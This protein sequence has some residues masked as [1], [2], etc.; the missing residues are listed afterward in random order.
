MHQKLFTID[1][2]QRFIAQ[3]P[4]E[5]SALVFADPAEPKGVSQASC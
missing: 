1:A 2:A 4:H 5:R 3:H